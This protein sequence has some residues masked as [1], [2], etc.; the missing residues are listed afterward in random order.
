MLGPLVLHICLRVREG[1]RVSLRVSL[2]VRE[3]QKRSAEIIEHKQMKREV[4]R[5]AIIEYMAF[6]GMIFRA[7]VGEF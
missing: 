5:A 7:L 4:S 1:Q 3:G 6:P 2:G